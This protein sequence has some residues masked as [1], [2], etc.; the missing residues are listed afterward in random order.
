MVAAP[1]GEPR[2]HG[3][4]ARPGQGVDQRRRGDQREHDDHG[5]ESREDAAEQAALIASALGHGDASA[6][7]AP[8]VRTVQAAGK[9]AS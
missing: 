5:E 3:V 6:S 4:A 8:A 2:G 7:A 1:L 9:A